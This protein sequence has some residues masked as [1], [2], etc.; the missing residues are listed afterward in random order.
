MSLGASMLTTVLMLL[1]S[2]PRAATSV[3]TNT[4]MCPSR[5][6][7]RTPIRVC[8]SWSPWTPSTLKPQPLSFSTS[9]STRARWLTNTIT[10]PWST[11][12][13]ILASSQPNLAAS[14]SITSTTCLMSSFAAPVRPTVTLMGSMSTSLA[15][16]STFFGIVAEKSIVCRSGRICPMMD[17][18]CGSKPMSNIRSASSKTRYVVRTQ[19]QA[20]ILR[21]SIIRPGVHTATSEPAF[22]CLNCSCLLS[23]PKAATHLRL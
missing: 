17:R 12:V 19:V 23:P 1:M 3:A 21:R 8:W 15:R 20:F 13:G 4:W 9:S 7:F 11:K 14:S 5:K 22:R 10:S 6:L 16:A 18:T 2:R